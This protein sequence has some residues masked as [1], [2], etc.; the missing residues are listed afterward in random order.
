MRTHLDVEQGFRRDVDER[1]KFVPP[2]LRAGEDVFYWQDDPSKI[3]QGRTSGKW[4]KVDIFAIKA[5]WLLLVLA[6]LS[7]RLILA[8]YGDLWT[9]W[10]WK[11]SRLVLFERPCC[12]TRTSGCST[13]RPENKEG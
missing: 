9:L 11:N 4:L 8:N 12:S 7:F 2:D 5:P 1:M 3:Q 6:L 10:I 13:N